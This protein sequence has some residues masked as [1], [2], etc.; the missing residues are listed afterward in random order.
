MKTQYLNFFT[1][2]KQC[3]AL[4]HF[5]LILLR[6]WVQTANHMNSTKPESIPAL[7]FANNP[8]FRWLDRT[9]VNL[10]MVLLGSSLVWLVAYWLAGAFSPLLPESGILS[11]VFSALFCTSVGLWVHQVR[12]SYDDLK[13]LRAN[14][15]AA[16]TP[17]SLCRLGGSVKENI[18]IN[19]LGAIVGIAIHILGRLVGDSRTTM[20]AFTQI[21]SEIV[22]FQGP[23]NI[24]LWDYLALTQF[25]LIGI[26][27]LQ[28]IVGHFRR[29]LV[30]TSLANSIPI[31]LLQ[32][33][34]L[35]PIANPLMRGLMAPVIVL[36]ASGPLFFAAEGRFQD[37]FYLLSVP[38]S[39]FLLL[40]TLPSFRA[41]VSLH[42]RIRGQKK[43]EIS[44][45]DRYLDGEEQVMQK[46]RLG[47]LQT[48]FSATEVLSYRDRVE[49]ISTWPLHGHL[50][51]IIFYLTIPPLAWAAAALVEQI[52]DAALR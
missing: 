38:T 49:S 35:T 2:V 13:L 51:R 37:A 15:S 7:P 20:D 10:A 8:G 24:I 36:A 52:V 47:C 50:P 43:R 1:T 39:L 14:T 6:A 4:Y 17:Q 26:A 3:G 27:L 22:L 12:A 30:F 28:G 25:I 48:Q 29:N 32:T 34:N 46:S 33:K 11:L 18:V 21:I 19:L 40:F 44:L 9:K 23:V 45:I 16:A 42:R 31:D 5:H 41:V